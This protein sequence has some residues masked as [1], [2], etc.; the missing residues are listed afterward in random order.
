MATKTIERRVSDLEETV[1]VPQF[2]NMRFAYVRAQLD[3]LDARV[4]TMDVKI[5]YMRSELQ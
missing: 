5:D 2:L 1:D 4:S 3:L